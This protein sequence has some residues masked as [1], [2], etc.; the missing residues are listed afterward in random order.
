MSTTASNTSCTPTAQPNRLAEGGL[1]DRSRTLT[2]T[3]D[4]ETLTGHPGDTLASALLA[5]GRV[6]VGSSIY[7]G[8]PRGILSAGL[9][10]PNALVQVRRPGHS[11]SESMLPATAIELVDGL[12]ATYLS[13]VGELDPER[14]TALYD[15]KYVHADV[16]VVGGGPAGLSAALQAAASG[17]R[18]VLVDDQPRLGGS[19]LS[20]PGATVDGLPAGA[21][22]EQTVERLHAHPEVTVLTR[23]S[24]MGS[25][26]SH[27]VNALEN[28]TDHLGADAASPDLTGVSRQR[29]WNIRAQQVVVAAGA[30]ERPLVFA[31][32]DR[33]GVM[34]ASAV[35][36]YLGRH[37]VAVGSRVVVATTND[38]VYPLVHELV[39]AGVE[40]AAVADARTALTEPARV[41]RNAGIRVETGATVVGTSG[42]PRVESATVSAIDDDGTPV[43]DAERVGCDLVA[44][45]GGWSPVVHLHCHRQGK[46][47]WHDELAAF[48]PADTV[49]GQ[50]VVG[51]ARGV[52]T[53]DGC[54]ADGTR[55]GAAAA[56]NAGFVSESGAEA[57]SAVVPDAVAP[58]V[59]RPLWVVRGEDGEL[60]GLDTHF[61]DLQRDQTVRDVMRAARTGMRSVEHI[62]R[63]TSISTAN[64]QGKTSA[65]N[66]IG[67][68]ATAQ[69]GSSPGEVGTTT[70]RAPYA[71]V[72]FAALAGRDRGDLFDPARVTSVHP[73]HVE[74][75]AQFEAVGQ[76]LR[77]WYYPRGEESIDEA[78]ARECAAVRASVGM[79]DATTLGKIEVRG[80][81]A[82]EF[83]NRVYTNAFKKLAP[84]SAR[85]GVMCTL[86]GMIFDDGVT[87]R[88]DDSRYF[89]TTTTGGA[90]R[91]LDWLE[92][93]HQTEW[94]DLDVTLTSVTEQWTTIA[95]V[96]PRSRE[97]L[98]RIAPDLDVD[99][100]A[101]P[102]MTYREV[103]L[104]SGIPARVCRISFSGELAYEVNVSG[105]YGRQVWED[106]A[107]AGAEFDITPYGTETMHVLRA[108]KGYPIVGQDT[109]GTVTP[110]D[111][112]MA[113]VVSKA[114][115]FIGKRSY[116]RSDTARPD[117]K[118]LVSLLPV[119]PALRLPEGC[120]LVEAGATADP[121]TGIVPMLGHVTS[122]YHSVALGRSFAL[123][124]VRGGRDRIG[125]TVT[126]AVG[127]DFVDVV[128]G[129]TVLYDPEGT[130]R[131]G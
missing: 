80:A 110:Q 46:V 82:G 4:G 74:H 89:M 47:R 63:Y 9:E 85:Y 76:W 52:F 2:F 114:K 16:L 107:E 20:D 39:A 36:T 124:L 45:S 111:A 22:V 108:E 19:L 75:G 17:A 21:W 69:G 127:D 15:K 125:Q 37:G 120:Q 50:Q 87:L 119:D 96:G 41:A 67:V 101:F 93:W 72:A 48:V 53:L 98:S 94:P 78:V 38:S 5:H 129:D 55:A 128:I 6:Q 56:F 88:L 43:G 68:I 104:A 95:V 25:Y 97:V 35:R 54:L 122:S 105:W 113:W 12:E 109:D 31:D 115:D 57:A 123:A 62:K 51:A 11:V 8:R 28:R 59:T 23:T 24:A 60:D 27:Y 49:E 99:N 32:N 26:D 18:V 34:L 3:V 40:V 100:D 121:D 70:Y 106:V 30:H 126:A 77:P 116:L 79:M 61:V 71:P 64:D 81:D 33:P 1:V 117:R 86:D 102:F 29:L 10:E 73:W 42:D 130:R 84:G 44:V 112:G 103:T 13:G 66:A 83:L 7:R 118:H 131:D 90:A 14:D 65:V 92:E 91:V 58:G